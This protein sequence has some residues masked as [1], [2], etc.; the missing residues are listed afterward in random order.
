MPSCPGT[1]LLILLIYEC[2][3]C[4]SLSTHIV[5]YLISFER[6][7]ASLTL[8]LKAGYFIKIQIMI[9]LLN[10]Q[11]QNCSMVSKS[12]TLHLLHIPKLPLCTLLL[13]I[14]WVLSN[15]T[16]SVAMSLEISTWQHKKQ[17]KPKQTYY[18]PQ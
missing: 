10:F 4:H 11:R 6:E 5:I 3:M 9:F 18:L 2:G 12:C 8:S 16:K 1:T 17:M 7:N 13:L 14:D 15:S